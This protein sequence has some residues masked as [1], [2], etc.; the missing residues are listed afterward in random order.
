[1]KLATEGDRLG[2]EYWGMYWDAVNSVS[3]LVAEA[4]PAMPGDSSNQS[5]S[6]K[7]PASEARSFQAKFSQELARGIPV[8]VHNVGLRSGSSKRPITESTPIAAKVLNDPSRG[9]NWV[10]MA[11]PKDAE[12]W[13]DPLDA[14]ILSFTAPTL[15]ASAF[16]I[17]PEKEYLVQ[18]NSIHTQSAQAIRRIYDQQGRHCGLWWEQAGY[19]Y[20]GLGL[21][22]EA[23]ARIHMVGISEYGDVYNP[24]KGPTRVEG[25]IRLFDDQAFPS[26]G[27]GSGIVNVLAVD[28]DYTHF[29]GVGHRCTVAVVHKKAWDA[30]DPQLKD[31]RTA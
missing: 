27:S 14:N 13:D 11:P 29:G 19:G 16:C 23:E 26:T 1:M 20:V 5:G 3:G 17:S 22:P 4:R 9:S 18:Q 30:V 6:S 28:L 8:K 12:R 25:E 24:R 2:E 21:D 10:V 7:Q 15:L 31:I